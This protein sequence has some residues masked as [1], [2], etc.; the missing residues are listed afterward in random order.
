MEPGSS[1]RV[2]Q[3][4]LDALLA[5]PLDDDSN[6]NL[7]LSRRGPGRVGVCL[8]HKCNNPG[9]VP[10]LHGSR[11]MEIDRAGQSAKF[12]FVH[13]FGPAESL[14]SSCECM[15]MMKYLE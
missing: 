9:T 10:V 5:Q 6:K 1:P 14:V 13:I 15:Q 7:N 11:N 8:W 3:T 12:L 2:E 4:K